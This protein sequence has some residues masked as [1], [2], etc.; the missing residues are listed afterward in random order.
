MD[1][2]G[3]WNKADVPIINGL[4]YSHT[5]WTLMNIMEGIEDVVYELALT[6]GEFYRSSVIKD[7]NEFKKISECYCSK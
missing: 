7:F 6:E 4:T 1:S 3:L 2:T 5:I